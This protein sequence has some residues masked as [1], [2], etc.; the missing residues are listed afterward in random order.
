MWAVAVWL[1]VWQILSVCVGHEILL[2]SPASV[3]LRLTELVRESGFWRSILF[4][5]QRITTGFMIAAVSGIVLAS[6]AARFRR[7]EELFAPAI[8]AVKATPVASIIILALVWVSSRN[9]SVLIS[10]LMV[11]P[12]MYANVLGGIK[13]ADKKLLEM[14]DVFGIPMRRRIPHIYVPQVFPFFHSA[15]SIAL[16]LCWKSGI[17]AEVIGIP[18]GSIGEKLYKAKIYLA[19]SDLFAWT[20]TIIMVSVAFERLFMLL[21][22]IIMDRMN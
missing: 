4:S 10:F 5:L 18:G 12:V 2:P 3:I 6:L 20:L 9:L 7:F 22:R 16:G 13:S 17:A 8:L 19:T 15:C 1:L 14:A 21:V 11:L